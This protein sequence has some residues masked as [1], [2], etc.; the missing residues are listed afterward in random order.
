MQNKNEIDI[1]INKTQEEI[2]NLDNK[3]QNLYQKK[4]ADELQKQE[5]LYNMLDLTANSCYICFPKDSNT[6]TILCQGF[7]I[8]ENVP[9]RKYF[10]TNCLKYRC[11]ESDDYSIVVNEKNIEYTTLNELFENNSVYKIPLNYY[12]QVISYLV[13]ELP[14]ITK[15]HD[16][17][18]NAT[19]KNYVEINI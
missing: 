18:Y 8:I 10:K 6:G 19:I 17:I 13:I 11:Y 1:E 14:D 12:K 4:I 16:D 15:F 2:K 7:Q 3:L 5:Q 9:T